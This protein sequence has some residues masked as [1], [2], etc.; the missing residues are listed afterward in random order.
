MNIQ[1]HEYKSIK[2]EQGNMLHNNLD[3][4]FEFAL[5]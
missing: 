4:S 5:F 1:F 3:P 2:I